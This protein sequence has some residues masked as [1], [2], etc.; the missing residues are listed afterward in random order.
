MAKYN[1]NGLKFRR[2]FTQD[3]KKVYDHFK[4]VKRESI[5]RDTKGKIITEFK[6]VEVPDFWSQVAVDILASKYFRKTGV[7]TPE[8]RETS[9]KQVVDRLVGTWRYWGEKYGYFASKE[10]A[11]VFED[12]LKYM[13]VDQIFAPNSPQWFNTGLNWAY[14]LTGP[15][16][17]HY[18]VDPDTEELKRSVDAYS[19]PQPHA[20]FILSIKDDLVNEG[21]I[22]DLWVREARLFKYGSGNG[23]N[24]SSL[25]SEGEPLSGGGVSS[26][27]MS[28]LKIGDVAA[29]AI[30][31]GGTTRRAAKMVILNI[32]HPEIEKFIMWKYHEEEK[33][34][35]LMELGY[36]GG[37]EGEAYQTVSGQ[38]SN[39]TVRVTNEFMEAVIN[40]KDWDLIRRTDKKVAKTVKARYL[41]DLIKKAAW[42]SAD[43]GL[44][45][46]TTIN[47][48]HTCPKSG[49][50][51]AS[52]P[53]SEYMFLDDTAC[54]LASINLVRFLRDDNFDVEGFKHAVR[55]ITVI[56]E[57]SV[58]MAQFPSKEIAKNSYLFRTLGIGYAN[59]GGLLMRMGIPYDSERAL[60]ITGAVTA[61]M[62][63]VAYITSAEMASFLGPFKEYEKNKEDM[64]R[65]IRNHRR[66]AYNAPSTEYE[67]LTIKPMGINEKHC[68]EY[69]LKE[70]R[71]S[72]DLALR[73]G[74]KYGYRNANVSVLAPTGTIGLLMDCDTTGI[75]PDYALVKFKK[76]VGGGYFKIINRGVEP[77]LRTLGYKENEIKEI[78]SYIIGTPDLRKCPYINSAK[79]IEKGFNDEIIEK[80]NNQLPGIFDIRQVFTREFLGDG[81]V[82]SLGIEGDDILKELGFSEEEI[83]KS[84]E[85]L[86]GNMEI[87]GAPYLKEEHLAVFDC[88]NKC[89]TKGKRYI[90]PLA[91]VKVMAAAQ[92]F[93]S[94]SISKTVNLPR[95]TTE[96][97]I[98]EIYMKAW[99]MGTKAIAIYRDGSKAIQ[100]LTMTSK[101]ESSKGVK[102]VEKVV[103]KVVYKPI[104]KKLPDE[105]RSITHKFVVAGNKGY[106]TVGMFE[107]GKPGEI[108][109][110]MAKEGSTISGIMDAFATSLSLN[111]QYGVPLEILIKKFS[112]MRFEP[113]GFTK[114]PEIPIVKSIIDYIFRWLALKF[115]DKD[116]AANVHNIS[117]VNFIKDEKGDNQKDSVL[118]SFDNSD[119]PSC[120][121]CGGIMVR[122]GS[123]Y[124]CL[125]CG[126]TTGCS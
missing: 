106:I 54:N 97:E 117:L 27:V 75:E 87:E 29:G 100:P 17:G 84:N 22:M 9:L 119:A 34:R 70:A 116:T 93:I 55:L 19:R 47:E 109:I 10:D 39:N 33:A 113:S 53:C 112:H 48:W 5:L 66:A 31:S 95:E 64:L 7:P 16:Q 115:L 26:G 45:F 18:Y 46:D 11:D 122:N 24:F 60:A 50:I 63:G 82:K 89:G 83:E 126:E 32:D 77:A 36:S 105:R 38:N 125:E 107:D 15:P 111:L 69:L 20:C 14:G 104:R 98:G 91:H 73:M 41:W 37:L 67:G 2:Y 81:F 72:W 58:L 21:G 101:E 56:L 30:K 80:I 61:I 114:N 65:V 118:K 51:N 28:F 12:E 96:D 102:V 79:L 25:R 71:E 42:G 85:F 94:G 86:C 88:A 62:T 40:D 124:K 4:W 103:E 59:L 43:P 92:P 49:R 35:K 52:N 1:K 76:L 74:E 123:C 3:G 8:G 57:I 78:I 108:F 13:L 23:T 99:E 90:S 44:Q 120:P 6:D 121:N 68:P 110:K